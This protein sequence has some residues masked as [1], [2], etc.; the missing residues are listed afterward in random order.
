MKVTFRCVVKQQ[1][2]TEKPDGALVCRM[3]TFF[4]RSPFF[5]LASVSPGKFR[6]SSV[7]EAT[8]LPSE[9]LKPPNE[10]RHRKR[11]ILKAN[12][13]EHVLEN[14]LCFIYTFSMYSLALECYK[15]KFIKTYCL[16]VLYHNYYFI[17]FRPSHFDL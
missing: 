13:L 6:S 11:P 5:G 1:D 16:S 17:L 10:L 9:T 2:A 15:C 4:N 7:D 14:N 12:N 8:S 3:S